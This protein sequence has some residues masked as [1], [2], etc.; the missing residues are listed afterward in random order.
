MNL[1]LHGKLVKG[2]KKK[3][4]RFLFFMAFNMVNNDNSIISYIYKG[5]FFP[6]H[7]A[8]YYLIFTG[9]LGQFI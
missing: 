3:R 5:Q 8:S 6:K 9:W 7:F 2:T 1:K 4:Y